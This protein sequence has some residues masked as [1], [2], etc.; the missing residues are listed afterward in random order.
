MNGDKGTMSLAVQVLVI[1]LV[2]PHVRAQ[3]ESSMCSCM[4][5][6]VHIHIYLHGHMCTGRELHVLMHVWSCAHAYLHGHMCTGREL[7]VLILRELLA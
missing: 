2:P 5:G 6:H 7:H 4:Y 3:E 1:S